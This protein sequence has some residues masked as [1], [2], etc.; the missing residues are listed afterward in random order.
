MHHNPTLSSSVLS[1]G[2]CLLILLSA[3][4]E[5][6]VY[7]PKPRAY[8][9]VVYPERAYQQF[10]EEYC[11]FSFEYPKYASIQQD[12][13]FFDERPVNA[14]WFDVYVPDF[15]AR[16]H[17]SYIPIDRK[18]SFEKLR[19]DAFNMANEHIVKANAIDEIPI[20]NP[21]G[22][23][24]FAFEFGGATATPFTFFL[25]DSTQHYLRGS[26]YFYTKSRP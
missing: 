8:P 1:F 18:N 3:C 22:V 9:K 26:L 2:L 15:N 20:Q 12:T 23:S 19:D 6:V 21:N 25:S 17:C 14:C 11:A 13:A 10:A 7:T 24:G 4:G 5:E 16:L